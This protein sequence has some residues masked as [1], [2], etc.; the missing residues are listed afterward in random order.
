MKLYLDDLRIP[1]STGWTIV[2]NFEEFAE[3]ILK[4]GLPAEMSLD[5]DLGE[6]I[7]SGYD[8]VKWLVE[9]E[10]DLRN[11]EINVHSAN[12]VGKENMEYLIYNWRKH[13]DKELEK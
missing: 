7:P 9:H 10:Y 2:R 11:V 5:H 1:K 13:L 8:C 12:P 6:D 3:H 4:Y